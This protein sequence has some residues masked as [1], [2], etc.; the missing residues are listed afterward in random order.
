MQEVTAMGVDDG[1]EFSK[2]LLSQSQFTV[3]EYLSD[4]ENN[5]KVAQE[6]ANDYYQDEIN[7]LQTMYVDKFNAVLK[8][9][10][11]EAQVMGA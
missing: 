2:A 7:N 11:K 5:Q 10:P 8:T 1:L 3:S 6:I 9:M 4:W